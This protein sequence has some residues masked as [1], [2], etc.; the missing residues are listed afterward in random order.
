[1][2]LARLTSAAL[3]LAMAASLSSAFAAP[4]DGARGPVQA[5]PISAQLPET[6]DLP[7]PASYQSQLFLN[8][9]ALDA[10]AIPGVAP[11]LVP[12]R[13]L[14]EADGGMAEWYPE[15]NQA[16]FYLANQRIIISFADNSVELEFKPVE[17]VTATLV[18]GVTFLPAS[19]INSLEGV[20]VNE[21]PELNVDRIDVQTPNGTPLMKLANE[22]LETAGLGKGMQSSPAEL[23]EVY[24]EVH[25]F[26]AEYMTEGVAF[27]PMMVSADT[28]IVGKMADGAEAGLKDFCEKYQN[29]QKETFSWYLPHNLPNIENAKFVTEGDWFMFLIAENADAAVELFHAKAA[30]LK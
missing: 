4:I 14:C 13:L 11:N 18:D 6:V 7:L 30:E 15:D 23:E 12:M 5:V 10:S 22:L 8:G 29:Q 27:L 16:F 26:K 2:K 28:L 3:A 20:E 1:M 9:E 21:N 25:G 17:G 19:F 24:G